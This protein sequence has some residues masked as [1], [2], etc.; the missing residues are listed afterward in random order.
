MFKDLVEIPSI[1]EYRKIILLCHTRSH[2]VV[3]RH[4][5][6]YIK[7]IARRSTRLCHDRATSC[8][9]RAMVVR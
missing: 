3:Q 8:N 2:D 5:T 4:L 9:G 1:V 6:I 7:D